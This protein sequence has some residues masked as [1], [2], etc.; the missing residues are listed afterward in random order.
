MRG[1]APGAVQAGGYAP[2]LDYRPATPEELAQIEDAL[3]AEWLSGDGLEARAIGYAVEHLVPRHLAR[4]REQREALIDKTRAAVH[5]RM[6]K[7]INYWDRRAAELRQ[8]EKEG[9]VNARSRGLRV[10][11]ARAQQRADELAARLERRTEE[12][13]LERQ[14]SAAPPV[15]IGGAIVLPIGLLLGERTP[16]E[17]LDTR[18]TEAIAM[19]AVIQTEAD[20][21]NHPRDVSADKLGYDVESLDPRTGRLRFIEVKGRRAGAETVTVSRNEILCGINV[22]EQFILALVLVEDGQPQVPRYVRRPF[23]QE[24][25][26]GV[27]SVNYDLSGLLSRSEGALSANQ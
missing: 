17:V 15:V 8:Q 3:A 24:P 25:D 27:T 18:I 13:A 23:S 20:L 2:Y 26:F 10:N 11:A 6:T 1:D 19:Q 16:P 5:E 7:E 22:P 9:K 4:V 21:D 12:L 14:I